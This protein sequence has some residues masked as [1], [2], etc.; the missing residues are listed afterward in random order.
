VLGAA[1]V[2]ACEFGE[3]VIATP[4]R[5]V[6]VHAVLAPEFNAQSVLVEELL[7]GRVTV[8]DS[9]LGDADD[10][11]VT[12]GGVPI[13]DA[14]VTVTDA[15]G[16]VAIA[17]E[18]H[19]A[20]PRPPGDGGTGVYRFVNAPSG[21]RGNTI[22]I[23]AGGRYELRVELR[24]GRVVTG[25][26]VVPGAPN[27][28]VPTATTFAQFNRDRDS[29]LLRWLPMPGARAYAVRVDS[30]LGPF[31]LFTDST[32]FRV[33]GELRNLFSD[34]LPRV[35][36]PGFRQTVSVAAVDVNYF[37]YYRSGSNPFTG[38]GIINRLE[39]GTGLFGA[40]VP[41]RTYSLQ[42]VGEVDERLEGRYLAQTS[43]GR[44]QLRLW[45]E[46][47]EGDVTLI[48]GSYRLPGEE[49]FGYTGT[50][51]GGRVALRSFL[52]QD[53][54]LVFRELVGEVR[55]DTLMLQ[56]TRSLMAGDDGR[57]VFV[58]TTLNPT[59]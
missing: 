1:S 55:G 9:L 47:R 6:V 2:S 26:S 52:N 14:R 23:Q 4:E 50:I 19:V 28:P 3:R 59:R 49:Q 27:A 35:F 37:D 20:R 51:E 33:T 18:T 41:I 5:R 34:R 30:P 57:R 40:Y 42:V 38:S 36:L 10:P 24:D 13:S 25:T 15:S 8:N 22:M 48:T 46:S 39:G 45:I 17:L 12:G 53:T 32:S 7:T 44:E 58:K 31:F 11:I 54:R 29:L 16:N 43:A 56:V 21:P